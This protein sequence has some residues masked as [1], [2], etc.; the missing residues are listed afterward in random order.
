MAREEGDALVEL[1]DGTQYREY[2]FKKE[3]LGSVIEDLKSKLT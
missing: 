3:D 1:A 2:I